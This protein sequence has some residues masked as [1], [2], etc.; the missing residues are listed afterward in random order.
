MAKK[1][2]ELDESASN[3]KHK[4]LKIEWVHGT[5]ATYS[6]Q[7]FAE[8]EL[9]TPIYDL[10]IENVR[11]GQ[12]I[13][14]QI[15][16]AMAED[17]F[18]GLGRDMLPYRW[19]GHRWKQCAQWFES[20]GFALYA[21]IRAPG[22]RGGPEAFPG[23]VETAWRSNSA[24]DAQGMNLKA[25]GSCK[26]IPLR[27]AVLVPK[28]Q[29]D[30]DQPYLYNDEGDIVEN[31]VFSTWEIHE[32]S[33]TDL[34]LH[35]IDISLQ[36]VQ[37]ALS[38]YDFGPFEDT[39]LMRFLNSSLEPDG[40]RTFQDWLGY[41]LVLGLTKNVE[42]MLYM[43][44]SGAN[45]KSQLLELIRGVVG[46]EACAEVRLSDLR[47]QA[48][49]EKLVG[50]LAMLGGEADTETELNTLKMLVSREPISCNPK[51]RDPF[52][53]EP[54]CLI[55]QAS[56]TKPEFDTRDG[57]MV[58]RVIPL[59]LKNTFAEE[60][61]GRIY[62]LA[63]KIIAE[64]YD[65]LIA[66]ALRG[67]MNCIVHGG[68]K[69][70]ETIKQAGKKV[71]AAGN[72]LEAFVDNLEAGSRYEIAKLELFAAYTTWCTQNH[73]P[74]VDSQRFYS[75]MGRIVPSRGLLFQKPYAA[76][77]Y[78]PS[79][80]NKR[81]KPCA[82]VDQWENSS[83]TDI[84]GRRPETYK[85]FRLKAGVIGDNPIGRERAPKQRKLK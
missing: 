40:V 30:P 49:L 74:A 76:S 51:Y 1:P 33:P 18:F 80:I 23:L 20:L 56:N 83:E 64:E 52:T 58:R 28:F 75:E 70:V 14:I 43:H 48:N 27:D 71:V 35:I 63:Q 2:V 53:I 16:M 72:R 67:A 54:E 45:G 7:V 61:Q 26:G 79:M 62:N 6:V 11:D 47:I 65:M 66:F 57:A 55:T 44:G 41:H 10:T 37:D 22:T 4:H 46:K 84:A 59:E 29:P 24:N 42:M 25:F 81:G 73:L 36:R 34:N 19:N 21:L 3:H 78:Q 12:S 8:N 13:V 50:K 9:T 32:H 82:L 31:P 15:A 60:K 17:P 5:A 69:P 77:N 38:C 68:F 39:Q 85:G